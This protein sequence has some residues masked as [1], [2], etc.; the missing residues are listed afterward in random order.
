MREVDVARLDFAAAA[1]RAAGSSVCAG[2]AGTPSDA[3]T[4][5]LPGYTRSTTSA[6]PCPTPM[7]IVHSA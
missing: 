1:Q 5:P 2:S 6:M 7:H 3:A 4:D